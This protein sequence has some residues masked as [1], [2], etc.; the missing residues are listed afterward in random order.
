MWSFYCDELAKMGQPEPGPCPISGNLAFV[1]LAVDPEAAWSEFGPYFLHETNSYG[2]SLSEG[3]SLPYHPVA[4]VQTL[5][6][7]GV[8]RILTPEEYVRESHAL[9][10]PFTVFKPMC[11]GTP[12]I[13][14]WSS[15]KLF[16]EEVLPVFR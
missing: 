13:L 9:P 8:Y 2:A 5:R 4:D 6:Q 11:G 1:T 16:E 10:S 12:P 15:L 14:A 7:E 3:S